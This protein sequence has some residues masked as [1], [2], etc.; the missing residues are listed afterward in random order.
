MFVDLNC[1]SSGDNVK[2]LY[3]FIYRAMRSFRERFKY[4][5]RQCKLDERFIRT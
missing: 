5:L 1:D 4:A 2:I 3:G